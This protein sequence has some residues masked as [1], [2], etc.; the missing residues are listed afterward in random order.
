MSTAK[1]I[2]DHWRTECSCYKNDFTGKLEI[3]IDELRVI[4]AQHD[5]LRSAIG[6]CVPSIVRVFTDKAKRDGESIDVGIGERVSV[7]VEEA[8]KD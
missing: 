3:P 6:A 2:M 7:R 8:M 1:E 4:L 5:K